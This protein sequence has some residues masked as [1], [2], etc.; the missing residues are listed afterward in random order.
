MA[1]EAATKNNESQWTLMKKLW[2]NKNFIG[3]AIIFVAYWGMCNSMGVLLNPLFDPGNYST[4]ALSLIGVSWIVGGISAMIGFG[5]VLDKTKAFVTAARLIS[6]GLTV[7]FC[8]APFIIPSGNVW[9]ASIWVFCIGFFMFPTMPT[10]VAF[11]VRLTHPI[12]AD[13]TNGLMV[14]ATYMYSAIW[15]LAGTSIF[16]FSF[17]IGIA[18]LLATSIVALISAFLIKDPCL[19]FYDSK[20]EDSIR[21]LSILQRKNSYLSARTDIS[22]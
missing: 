5:I 16:Y 18:C 20:L 2:H 3:T 17:M 22:T 11:A 14:S 21:S 7:L 13:V 1:L 6:T 8:G 15:D 9:I 4:S 10:C 19:K 12:P